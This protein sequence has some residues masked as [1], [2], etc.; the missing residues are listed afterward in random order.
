MI[1]TLINTKVNTI[2]KTVQLGTLLNLSP[3]VKQYI[4]GLTTPLSS[5]QVLRLDNRVKGIKTRL[6]ITALSDILDVFYFFANQTQESALRNIVKDAHH[7]TTS[8]IT[9]EAY[10]GLK[11]NKTSQFIDTNYNPS[12]AL[13]YKQDD[14]SMGA[15]VSEMA[16]NLNARPVIYGVDNNTIN[17]R[18]QP[19]SNLY[20]H[21]TINS[22]R[23]N[24]STPVFTYTS[25]DRSF[26]IQNRV[27]GTSSKT[28]KNGALYLSEELVSNG[29]PNGNVFLLARNSIGIGATDYSDARLSCWFAGKGLTES[30]IAIINDEIEKYMQS[31]NNAFQVKITSPTVIFTFD[32]GNAEHA[33]LTKSVF[34]T[35]GKKCTHFIVSD[36]IGQAGYMTVANLQA[37]NAAGYDLQCHSKTHTNPNTL[38]ESQL[39]AE[40]QAVDD[41]FVANSLPAPKHHAYP[42]GVYTYISLNVVA[43]FRQSARQIGNINAYYSGYIQNMC[44]VSTARSVDGETNDTIFRAGIDLAKANN[45]LVIYY[46]HGVYEN[47][48]AESAYPNPVKASALASALDYAIAKG[49][50]VKT[51]SDVFQT[52]Y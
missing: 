27:S 45:G 20:I 44:R 42:G 21:Y 7:A 38:S 4:S 9:F 16:T 36:W 46:A 6:G 12:T 41:F 26:Y 50:E 25:P 15:Y 24:P 31:V 28:Y 14:A 13:R 52:D 10:K 30:Q 22:A 8:A 47:D 5:E 39:T 34:D 19:A 37:L 51:M 2:I 48:P 1:N 29:V 18:L 43:R 23:A 32:D 49:V 40:F 17:I 11:G 35:Y 3:E 33:T